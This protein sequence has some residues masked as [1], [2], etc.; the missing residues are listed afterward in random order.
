MNIAERQKAKEK[1]MNLY[2]KGKSDFWEQPFMWILS[3]YAML[4]FAF[5]KILDMEMHLLKSTSHILMI[6][7][8]GR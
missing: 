5:G 3:C 7:V 8:S 6:S 4:C 2:T 1:K